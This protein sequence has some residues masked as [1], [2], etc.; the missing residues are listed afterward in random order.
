MFP[1]QGS[2]E[3]P[4][5]AQASVVNKHTFSIQDGDFQSG[6]IF[7]NQWTSGNA[8]RRCS[9]LGDSKTGQ[10]IACNP[11]KHRKSQNA[12]LHELMYC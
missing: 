5:Y 3:G 2:L 4:G 12:K 10:G 11:T 9:D 8:D 7:Q 6:M 1:A